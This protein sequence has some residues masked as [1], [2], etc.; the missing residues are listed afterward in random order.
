[1]GGYE[2]GWKVM[3]SGGDKS[4]EYRGS[5]QAGWR[6]AAVGAVFVGLVSLYYWQSSRLGP[7]CY[8]FTAS[9]IGT[10]EQNGE[11]VNALDLSKSTRRACVPV[12]P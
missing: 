12:K 1:M 7:E 11:I 10:L 3:P 4:P 8:D 2:E 9:D 6:V 5:R